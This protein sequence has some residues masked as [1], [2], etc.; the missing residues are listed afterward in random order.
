MDNSVTLVGAIVAALGIVATAMA[1]ML[2]IVKY[3]MVQ[4]KESL[5]ANTKSNNLV[6]KESKLTRSA[7]KSSDKYLRERNG[8]D[9]EIHTELIASINK[10]PH[11]M[12]K[13]ADNSVQKLSKQTVKE[14]L[15]THQTVES[16]DTK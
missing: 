10:L 7:V 15:V 16:Q 1:G 13:I 12:Q 9:S 2:W 6:A 3:L 5:D 14:Q 8:R 11:T 4:M